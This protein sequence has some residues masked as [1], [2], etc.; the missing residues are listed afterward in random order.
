MSK[1]N[2][3]KEELI[4]K[5]TDVN[6]KYLKTLLLL[7]LLAPAFLYGQYKS[8][9]IGVRGAYYSSGDQEMEFVSVE[10]D[11]YSTGTNVGAGGSLFIF[12]RVSDHFLIE[13]TVGGLAR[14]NTESKVCFDEEVEVFS[15]VPMLVGA[16]Y[17][18][19]PLNSKSN[20]RP[21]LSIGPGAYILSDVFVKSKF[22]VDHGYVKTSVRGGMH[23]GAGFN[24]FFTE[25]FGLNFETKYHMVDFNPDHNRSGYELGLG[26]V[27]MWGDYEPE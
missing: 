5:S 18:I 8:T 20:L 21:Y 7:A 11:R 22:G 16:K 13:F 10:Y 12:S 3:P 14:V 15:A 25:T 19:L 1:Q 2:E 6:N 27:F 26:L 4:M 24:F 23:A 9:G 17:D